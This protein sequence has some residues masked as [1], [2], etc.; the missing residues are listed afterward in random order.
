MIIS[1]YHSLTLKY[2]RCMELRDMHDEKMKIIQLQVEA[3]I[4][5]KMLN[6]NELSVTVFRRKS[7]DLRII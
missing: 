3:I 7:C 1:R 4:N 5:K 2:S 6:E